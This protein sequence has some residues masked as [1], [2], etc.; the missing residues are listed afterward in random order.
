[1]SHR[2]IAEHV[3]AKYAVGEWWS[4]MVTV[5]YE[6]LAGLRERHQKADGFAASASR[7]VAADLASLYKA[8][9]D[10]R[11]RR[12]WLGDEDITIRAAT[13]DKSMRI[14]W[15]DGRTHVDVN[16][17]A[18][19]PGRSQV[20]VQHRKLA[21]ARDVERIKKTWGERLDALRTLLEK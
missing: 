21:A 16:F 17:Y 4:Q 2:K 18:K 6:R 9:S 10:P 8:W 3:Q 12:R 1:M 13:A 20:A 7:T 15:T 5:G 14:T 19:G 11:T